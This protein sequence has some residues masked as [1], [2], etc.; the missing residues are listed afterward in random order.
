MTRYNDL[1][2]CHAAAG[3]GTT[4]AAG[5]RTGGLLVSLPASELMSGRG[6]GFGVGIVAL[7]TGVGR[8]S[9]F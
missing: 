1:L 6:G 9:T 8:R 4:L 5:G 7:G 2:S 3:T